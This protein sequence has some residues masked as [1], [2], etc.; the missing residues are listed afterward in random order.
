LRR[1]IIVAF[2]LVS[3]L[4]SLILA[5]FLYRFVERQLASELR[6]RL[7]DITDIGAHA[8]DRGAYERL[9]AQLADGDLPAPRVQAIEA[10]ADYKA[11]SDQLG[12]L[13]QTEASLVRYA[14]LLAPTADPDRPRFV[15]DADVLA[16]TAD[17]D[18]VSHFAKPYDVA[19]LPLL[20]RAL[21]EC[22]PFV[23][24]DFVY[25]AEFGVHSVSAYYPVGPVAADG[26]CPGVLGVDITDRDMRAALDAAGGLAIRISLLVIAIALLVSIA[27]GTVLTRSVLALSTTVKRFADKDFTARTAI[28]SRDEIGV[29]GANFNTMADTIQE[30]HEHLEE[31][32]KQRTHELTEEKATSERLLLNVLPPPIAE[33]L[34]T[35]DGLIVDRFDDVSVL[36]ADIVGFTA[37]SA[38]TSPE[39]LVTML[40]E[41]FTAFDRLA[42]QH[43]LEKI[44]TIGD[45]YMV[46]A[47]LPHPIPEPAVAMTRMGLAMLDAIDAYARRTGH[48]LTI[49]IGIHTG[50]VVAGVIGRKKFI[51]D[52]WGD[53]VNT[54]SRMESHG[55]PG[56]LHVSAVTRAAIGERFVVEG[57]GEIEIK[58]KGPMTTFLVVEEREPT[59]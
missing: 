21:V 39:A 24:Q 34:K 26:R 6:D 9:H 28:A 56:R 54:A 51:Y 32:V 43:G 11:I 10:S 17:G 47:G 16:G 5:L 31:L 22:R 55:L 44:K 45:C 30:H 59:S 53:T 58:G 1:K 57:R 48:D 3:T 38:R 46:V 8:I 35:G 7:R 23:E 33:R 37:M 2:F 20:R 41:L 25:D 15:V 4:I 49:R 12:V 13:R 29:L 14:Y 50:S 27:M 18:D 36:F 52:L 42:E 19:K 40:D